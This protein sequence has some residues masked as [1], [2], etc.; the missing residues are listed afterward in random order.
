ML[1]ILLFAGCSYLSEEPTDFYSYS[2]DGDLWRVPLLEPFEIVSA[3]NS[4]MNDWLLIVDQPAISGPDFKLFGDEFQFG[5]LTKVGIKDSVIVLENTN[6]YWPKLSGSYPGLLI[7]NTKTSELLIYSKEH[8]QSAI[9]STFIELGIT[10]IKMRDWRP[11][12]DRFFL[13]NRSYQK[14]G[15][16]RVAAD[17]T[18]LFYYKKP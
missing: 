5:E 11:L 10:G 15:G 8:H 6:Q 13:E 18:V 3:T 1:S 2:K 4:D 9:D 7:I 14:V 12:K 16:S 17:E